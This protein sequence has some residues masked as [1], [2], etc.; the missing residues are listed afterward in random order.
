MIDPADD[1]SS[2]TGMDVFATLFVTFILVAA[3]AVMLIN[4][5]RVPEVD[6]YLVVG[7]VIEGG[8][9]MEMKQ[10]L[11]IQTNGG[12]W[13]LIKPNGKSPYGMEPRYTIGAKDPPRLYA[14]FDNPPPGKY[15]VKLQNED[16]STWQGQLDY[17]RDFEVCLFTKHPLKR[18]E[19]ERQCQK[20]EFP[21]DV[22]FHYRISF[23]N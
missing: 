16:S 1:N 10:G 12:A 18:V 23:T 3:V 15:T 19:P 5:P 14:Y 2:D 17:N 21:E 8:A 13:T 9:P 20:Q 7:Y 11:L 4:V 22:E 6:R